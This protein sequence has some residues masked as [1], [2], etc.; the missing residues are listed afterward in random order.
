MKYRH[1]LYKHIKKLLPGKPRSFSSSSKLS[2][3][4]I[5]I[6]TLLTIGRI[7]TAP[8]IVYAIIQEQWMKG[9]ILFVCAAL[10]DGVDGYLARRLGQESFLGAFLDPLADKI[11]MLSCMGAFVWAHAPLSGIPAWFLS[12]ML[13]KEIMII[14]GASLCVIIYGKKIIQPNIWG[15]VTTGAQTAL[16]SW[17]LCCSLCNWAPFKTY[18]AALILIVI[19]SLITLVQYARTGL[20]IVY[21]SS[22]FNIRD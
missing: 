5:T 7:I 17:L 10:S 16:I 2:E 20:R 14:I 19:L 11:L 3:Y 1:K 13:W 22:S 8:F 18:Y 15:K 21:R 9:L 4:V 12:I 6:P